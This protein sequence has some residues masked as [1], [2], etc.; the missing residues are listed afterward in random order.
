[1]STYVS[2]LAM[3]TF[4]LNHLQVSYKH[5]V[6]SPL[7]ISAGIQHIYNCQT[8]IIAVGFIAHLYLAPSPELNDLYILAH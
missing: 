5:H 3:F 2:I 7:T 4:S 8:T 6:T 1:M